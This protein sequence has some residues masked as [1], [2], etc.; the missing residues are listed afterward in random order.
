MF[1]EKKLKKIINV[2]KIEETY[3]DTEREPLEKG[4]KKAIAIAALLVF[5][6]VFLI[7][8]AVVYGLVWLFVR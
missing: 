7:F 5:V 6:P 1:F 3:R 4:D 8:I 2:E